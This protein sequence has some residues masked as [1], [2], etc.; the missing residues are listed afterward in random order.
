MPLSFQTLNRGPIAF[1]FFNTETDLLL[2]N[3]YFIF[4]PEFC[5]NMEALASDSSVGVFSTQWEVD[6]I[7]D[8]MDIG[9]LMGAI[10]N[11]RHLGFIG[12]VYKKLPFPA[13][14]EDFHQNP[15]GYR[16]RD[17][18]RSLLDDY[19]RQATIPF[20]ADPGQG[21]VVIGDFSFSRSSFL[22]LVQYVWLGGYPRWRDM[23]RPDYVLRMKERILGGENP[24]FE[25]F[26]FSDEKPGAPR[27]LF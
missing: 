17:E 13:D 26:V 3:H 5:R 24:V 14:P 22:E 12:D 16:T 10:H 25:G 9:D 19:S 2:M 15:E 20:S 23:I 4:A 8:P 18:I 11:I 27:L 21:V 7:E 6:V 1:G